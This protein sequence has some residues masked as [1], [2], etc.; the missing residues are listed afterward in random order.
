VIPAETEIGYNLEHDKKR[1]H[2]TDSGIVV[3]AK[4]TEISGAI[5][6]AKMAAERE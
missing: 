1:Y 3:I 5:K 6:D 2:V 4:G